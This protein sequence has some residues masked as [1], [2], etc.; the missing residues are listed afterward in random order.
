MPAE[1]WDEHTAEMRAL[2][3]ASAVAGAAVRTLG[4]IQIVLPEYAAVRHGMHEAYK[5]Y[6]A[7]TPAQL[8]ADFVNTVGVLAEREPGVTLWDACHLGQPSVVKRLLAEGIDANEGNNNTGN[9]GATTP[10]YE[11][12]HK[13]FAD[14]VKLMV[15]AGAV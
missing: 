12:S 9:S 6:R 13:W 7:E 4:E 8:F 15:D 1:R 11:A 14:V 3:T 5:L 2:L 10:L